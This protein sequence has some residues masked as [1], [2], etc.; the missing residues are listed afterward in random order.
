[1][2]TDSRI[3]YQG[4]VMSLRTERN[5]NAPDVDELEYGIATG[6]FAL[7]QSERVLGTV[8]FGRQP[9][10]ILRGE[11]A[12][13]ALRQTLF[14]IDTNPYAAQKPAVRQLGKRAI[15]GIVSDFTPDNV[16]T[17]AIKVDAVAALAVA[18]TEPAA[19]PQPPRAFAR[20]LPIEINSPLL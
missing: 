8:R 6:Y 9:A 15:W 2:Y 20:L 14:D 11:T 4:R 10:G 16:T 1:M 7:A 3:T 17:N 12:I 13:D 5:L 18:L 19:L